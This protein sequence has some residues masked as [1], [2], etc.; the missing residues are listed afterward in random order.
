MAA[1]VGC[2]STSRSELAVLSLFS[3]LQ[4]RTFCLTLMVLKSDEMCLSIS[5][6]SASP[7]R[8]PVAPHKMNTIRSLGFF[9]VANPDMISAEKDGVFC[10]SEE[11]T[12]ELQSL[13]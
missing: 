5:I 3:T 1:I 9:Q 2:R 7:I 10:R 6:P 11:H 8:R 12:S 4:C 13:R